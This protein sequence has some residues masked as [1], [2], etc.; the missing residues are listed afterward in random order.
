MPDRDGWW[1]PATVLTDVTP[2]MTAFEEELFGPTAAIIEA[3]DEDEA[4]M[5]ANR[6]RFGLGAGI[7]TSDIERGLELAR[8]RIETGSCAINGF[9]SS[10]PRIP[11]GG[12]RESGYGRELGGPGIHEFVNIKTLVVS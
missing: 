8:N 11:F 10:D 12:I 9:V 6:S 1:Y 2:G 3:A 4:I 5:L 7:F